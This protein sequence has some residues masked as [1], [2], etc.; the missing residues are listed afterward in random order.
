MSNQQERLVAQLA[1]IKEL[2]GLSL[3]SLAR[4]SGLS[5]SSLS[6]Y[7]TGRLV[8][9]WEAV[10]AL[11]RAVKKDPRPLRAIWAAASEAGPAPAPRRNDLPGDLFDFTGRE[12]ESGQVEE[13][14]RTV[15]AVVIDG[16][17]GVGKTSLALHVAHRLAPAYP[18][19]GLYLD[20]QGFTPGQ[21]PLD[22]QVALGRL[23]DG[24][25]VT[26]PPAGAAE[27]AALWRSELS[28]R[29]ALVVLDNA[30]DAAQVRPL[31]P[32]AGKSAVLITSRN[33]LVSLDGVPPVS[34]APFGDA[35][36]ARLFGR[37][38]G[39]TLDAEGAVDQVLRE[40]GG[41]PLAL[42]MAGA[43]LRHRPGWTV[44]VLAERMRDNAG[45]FDAVFGMSLQQL[46]LDQ[47]RMFRLLGVLPG[48]DFDD[49]VASALI[50]ADPL[51]ILDELV[52]AH[53]IQEI[54]P[55]RYRLHDLI[56]RYAA[57]LAA[58]EEAD[59][60]V[61]LR[62]VFDH[63]LARAIAQDQILPSPH[64]PR[65]QAGDPAKAMAWFDLEYVN[66][67]ACF[68]AAVRL[69]ADE[70]VAALPPAMRVW[71][72]RHRGTDDQTR[73]LAAAADA[74]GRLGRDRERA[75]LL[76]DLGFALA[77]AGRLTEALDAYGAA[78]PADDL[79]ATLALR[80]GFVHRDLGDPA[81]AQTDFRRAR[82]LFE[83]Q[84]N[85]A[86]QSQALAFDGWATLHLGARD[87]A[88]SL[89]RSSLELVEGP[90][91]IPGLLTLGVAEGA[92]GPVREALALAEQHRLRHNEAWCH[93]CLGIVLRETGDPL[94]A[95][96]HHRRALELLKP[97]AEVQL[98][99]DCLRAYAETCAAA[100]RPDEAVPALDRLRVL[101][102]VASDIQV[103]A[104]STP[105]S[106]GRVNSPPSAP[107]ASSVPVSYRG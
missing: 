9:P 22:P 37:A 84:G 72:F 5:S 26:H 60:S 106:I 39:L 76:A 55:G 87:E 93:N 64:R 19:G 1:Q 86:G 13:L 52:D 45:R 15:G 6:R 90:A 49:G 79:A 17:A 107:S 43:R 104:R 4:A 14:L 66:L 38:A 95:L 28:R 88:I 81:A 78:D 59:I 82:K 105:V 89:A 101:T 21:E 32:G 54:S 94:R 83:Q 85:R 16:M 61:Y 65:P 46:D 96:D 41:L 42:R 27:R 73:M 68:D 33:R 70:F 100:D 80:T 24:L 20:L 29:R 25:D 3:R 56:R 53:L 18:D 57:D 51:E 69:G 40:C 2:S 74:A 8:P 11:C 7:L 31:L 77:A 44:A 67:I 35:D 97:L 102:R 103:P 10:V 12:A 99:I 91:R 48:A 47:R 34:L 62:R 71:F 30:A 92:T 58:S 36:A 50:S 63:Y 75:S 23:L 98:E